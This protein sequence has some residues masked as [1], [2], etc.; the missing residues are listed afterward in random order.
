MFLDKKRELEID[1]AI[2]DLLLRVDMSFPEN[3]ISDLLKRLDIP[4]AVGP[5]E[6][7]VSGIVFNDN[8]GVKI[9]VNEQDN[10]KRRT[11][12]LA[13]ELGHLTLG[14]VGTKYRIDKYDYSSNSTEA[15]E[16]TEANYFAAALLV[17]KRKLLQV[18]SI[19]HDVNMIAAYFGVSESVINNRMNWI[20]I[21]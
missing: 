12:S 9:A 16:E 17:P 6:L 14:H 1:R 15:T 11:F 19:T 10:L 20:G 8:N 5:L 2:S 3:S 18:L 7:N 21:R 4:Y 13:H